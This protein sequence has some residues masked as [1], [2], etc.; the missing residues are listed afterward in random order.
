MSSNDD[1]STHEVETQPEPEEAAAVEVAPAGA[2]EP[3]PEPEQAPQPSARPAE[4]EAATDAEAATEAP[5][6]APETTAPAPETTAPAPETTAPAAEAAA[7]AAETTAATAEAAAPAA[8]AP[9]PET[10][11][12]AAEAGP[13]AP[14]I[15]AIEPA[16]G[17]VSGGTAITIRGEHFDAGSKVRLGAI[18]LDAALE[19]GTLRVVA[20]ARAEPGFVDVRVVAPDGRGE[21]RVNGFHFDPPPRLVGVAPRTVST[22]G[23]ATLRI[24]GAALAEGCELR[25]AGE[26]VPCTHLG[27]GALEAIAPRRAAGLVEVRVQN[28]D[29]QSGALA[30]V[31][32]FD[33]GP[34]VTGVTPAE[35]TLAGGTEVIITGR[36][37]APGCAVTFFDAAPNVTY[38]GET[39]LRITAPPRAAAGVGAV[40]VQNPDG[41]GHALESAFAYR[42]AP[43]PRIASV[44]PPHGVITGG[45]RLTIQ[46]SGFDPACAVELGGARLAV[47]YTSAEAIHVVAPAVAAPGPVE[48]RVENPDG[49][50]ATLEGGFTYRLPPAPPKLVAV[51]PGRGFTAGGQKVTLMGDN[52]DETTAVRIAE[53]RTTVK[54]VSRTELEALVPPRAEIGPVAVE[55]FT[56]DGIVVRSEDA[57]VYEARPAPRITGVTP[58]AGPTTGGT[59]V[60]IEGERFPEGGFVRIGREPPKSVVSRRTERI[61]VIT[62]A[63]KTAGMVDVEVGGSGVETA[64]MKNAFKYEPRP[65]PVIESVAPNR[66]GTAGGTELSI[67]GKHFTADAAVLVGGKPVKSAKLTDPTTLEV[68]TPPGQGG[69]MVDVV[70]RNP[71]GKEAVARRAFLYD[72]RYG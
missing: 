33:D 34:V 44:T 61:E 32:R 50:S 47:S 55:L 40:R 10:T 69:Q 68:K 16:H 70:V 22:A 24:E 48:L 13:P 26:A 3:A 56:P 41:L 7:P 46:G 39:R 18:E 37:F 43:C 35:A 23:G 17:P 5:A 14:R 52:F 67:T 30:G 15:L 66:G 38:D 45:A 65:A 9:A 42:V 36:G 72:E 8:T 62:A 57:F 60:V 20:P 21:L 53:V 64:V 49:Q 28:P 19:G 4:A 29:G 12:L 63:T 2:P 25:I 6:P 71:D 51:T 54:L 58:S 27:P 11:A 31:L 1:A 59:R